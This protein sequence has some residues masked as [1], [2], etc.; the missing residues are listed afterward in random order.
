MKNLAKRTADLLFDG[1]RAAVAVVV[2]GRI[3]RVG[4][5]SQITDGA[6]VL[7]VFIAILLI[8][9]GYLFDYLSEKGGV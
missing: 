6:F 8:G 1:F 7:M 2:F 4:D 9:L 5:L 3:L